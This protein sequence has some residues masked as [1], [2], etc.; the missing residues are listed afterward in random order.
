MAGLVTA[1]D[2]RL[3]RAHEALVTSKDV[4]FVLAPV[5]PKPAP[6]AWMR[7]FGEWLEQMLAALGRAL[8][9]IATHM[10]E[11]PYARIFLWTVLALL[12]A[13]IAWTLFDR[14]RHGVW[15][16]PGRRWTMRAAI[17]DEEEDWAPE[18]GAARAWL[19][20]ADAL[21]AQG[22]YEEAVHH[23]LLR[24]V[25]DLSRRRP[26]IVRPALTSRDLAQAPGVP[27]A[28]RRMFAQI[29]QAVERSL[30]GGRSIDAE[31]W[32]TCRA[33]YADFAQP[34]AWAP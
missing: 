5:P 34:R 32:A 23:L 17:G 3:A 22:R 24:S 12:I 19:E 26:D 10:P 25:D 11:A 9:W 28:P 30:F 8:R 33:A 7:A 29:A 4:Q 21:A 6:P 1:P 18:A 14:L 27:A 16:W 15:R 2:E 13:L 20:S 31:G